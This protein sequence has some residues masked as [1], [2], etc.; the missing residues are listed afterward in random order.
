[1]PL[2]V[3]NVSKISGLPRVQSRNKSISDKGIWMGGGG[4]WQEI[5]CRRSLPA[6]SV[7]WTRLTRHVGFLVGQ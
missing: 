6:I 5:A 3:P 7:A 2:V 4:I 1:L